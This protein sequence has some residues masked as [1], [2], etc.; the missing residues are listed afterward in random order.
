VKVRYSTDSC[1]GI[2]PT[3]PDG[4]GWTHTMVLH[5]GSV[6]YADTAAEVVDEFMPGYLDADEDARAAAR[7]RHARK[8]AAVAQRLMIERARAAGVFDPDDPAQAQIDELLAMDKGL[9]L[10][11]ELPDAPGRPADWLP[12]VGLVLLTTSYEPHT[13]QPRIGGNVVWID[14]TTDDAYLDSLGACGVFS[15]WAAGHVPGVTG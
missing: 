2:N 11:L 8:L 9:S 7:I 10:G 3:R 12:A 4:T 6:V 15:Y 5:D 1:E 13:D 14:P